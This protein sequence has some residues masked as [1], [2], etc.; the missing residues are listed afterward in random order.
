MN[1]DG[2]RGLSALSWACGSR[3]AGDGATAVAVVGE[4]FAACTILAA[5]IPGTSDTRAWIGPALLLL[6]T[7]AIAA[8][9]ER[10]VP[11]AALPVAVYLLVYA[12]IAVR[13]GVPANNEI[14]RY[15]L[16][17]LLALAVAALPLASAAR[18]RLLLLLIGLTLAEAGVAIAQALTFVIRYGRRATDHVDSVTGT[19]GAGQAGILAFFCLLGAAVVVAWWLRGGRSWPASVLVA[20]A[21]VAG[22][23]T[24][25]RAVAVVV[26]VVAVAGA[27]GLLMLRAP[28][29]ERR[30]LAATAVGGVLLGPV[31][32]GA[33][34]GV[35]PGSFASGFAAQNAVVLGRSPQAQAAGASSSAAH[36]RSSRPV[37]R[38]QPLSGAELLPGRF[39]QLRLALSLSWGSGVGAFLLGRGPGASELD[40]AYHTPKSV[41]RPERTGSTWVGR[42]LTDAG[43]V[44]L[45]AFL[46]LL[47]WLALLAGP[48]ARLPAAPVDGVLATALPSLAA[49]T[50]VGAVDGTILDVR[51]YS[52]P[53]WIVVGLASGSRVA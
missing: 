38:R 23:A 45:C 21:L 35:Y 13:T 20:S 52:L 2:G 39:A 19:L 29:I 6:V 22:I 17:P 44:G 27:A 34:A 4:L 8:A 46:A 26:P 47:L 18:L 25:T 31:L 16:R 41:P 1:G 49:L 24:S 28:G 42:V 10:A 37:R 51:S 33:I 53:F 9:R 50:A 43:W 15:L 7:G 40:P 5:F 36:H 11:R 48:L 32:Y 30:R 3:R 14:A 12:A